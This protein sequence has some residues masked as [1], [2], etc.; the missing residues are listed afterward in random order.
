MALRRRVEQPDPIRAEPGVRD[1]PGCGS[2]APSRSDRSRCSPRRGL[3]PLPVE[4]ACAPVSRRRGP[5]RA[6][7]GGRGRLLHSCWSI[8]R[9]RRWPAR[10][11]LRAVA[12]TRRAALPGAAP[13]EAACRWGNVTVR[14]RYRLIGRCGGEGLGLARRRFSH[15]G[16]RIGPQLVTREH[17]PGLVATDASEQER[18]EAVADHNVLDQFPDGDLRRRR[19]SP[20]VRLQSTYD[21]PE[22][23]R[24]SVDQLHVPHASPPMSSHSGVGVG[25]NASRAH[26]ARWVNSSR[27]AI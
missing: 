17:G 26:S 7:T 15:G 3:V 11:E 14:M 18:G 24:R 6:P 12:Q 20:R 16:D 10:V 23:G 8:R 13:E 2:A 1:Q 22:L 9:H 19:T 4:R 5:D 21:A 27:P 25:G